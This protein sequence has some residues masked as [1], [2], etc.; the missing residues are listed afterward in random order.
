MAAALMRLGIILQRPLDPTFSTDLRKLHSLT[1]QAVQRLRNLVFHLRPPALDHS[2][3][4]AALDEYLE[5]WARDA[6]IIYELHSTLADEPSQETRTILF[7]IAQ[8]ALSNVR[9][10]A[11]ATTVRI[12]L[13]P[14]DAGVLMR[15]TDD[16]VGFEAERSVVASVGHIGLISMRERAEVAGGWCEVDGRAGAATV[17]VCIPNH[18]ATEGA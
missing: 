9:K 16:G 3:I 2:G 6:E 4:R 18:P 8:E 1:E 5:P 17:Q 14:R 10:H 15:I 11:H 7:R 13:E 12:T